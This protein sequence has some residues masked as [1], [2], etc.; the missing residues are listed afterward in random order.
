MIYSESFQ[1]N[2]EIDVETVWLESEFHTTEL[3]LRGKGLREM[4]YTT[5]GE[6]EI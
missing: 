6:S 5:H 4:L 1:H 3:C 2:H